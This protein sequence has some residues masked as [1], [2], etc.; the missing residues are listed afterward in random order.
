MVAKWSQKFPMKK[1]LRLP[2]TPVFVGNEFL[3]RLLF[4][5]YNV[6]PAFIV[7]TFVKSIPILKLTR[8][9]FVGFSV[10]SVFENF[11]N[12]DD[13]N[14]MEIYSSMTEEDR[15]IFPCSVRRSPVI[16]YAKH[17][18]MGMQKYMMKETE[19][20]SRNAKGKMKLLL[21]VDYLL[22]AVCSFGIYK[23]FS[24]IFL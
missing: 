16:D 24:M 14:L 8:Q 11:V 6:I 23:I 13:K 22:T 9:S 19:A 5:F 15:K 4:I 12:Y 20:D 3:Y 17:M 18:V 7:E 10:I 21:I 1:T 2:K